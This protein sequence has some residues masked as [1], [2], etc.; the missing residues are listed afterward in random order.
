MLNRK[1]WTEYICADVYK[2]TAPI[3]LS[4]ACMWYSP[5]STFKNWIK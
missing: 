2:Q 4:E 5:A 3:M 1:T